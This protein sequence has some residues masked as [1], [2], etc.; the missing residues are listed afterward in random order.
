[1]ENSI[2]IVYATLTVASL[3]VNYFDGFVWR[4]LFWSG[5]FPHLQISP[6]MCAVGLVTLGL[7]GV[8]NCFLQQ[9]ETQ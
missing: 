4:V 1:M 9:L 3:S 8:S 5:V 7:Y 2:I 6:T